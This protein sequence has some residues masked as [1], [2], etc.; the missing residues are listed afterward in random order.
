MASLMA[1]VLQ[2][3]NML[4]PSNM[5]K[6]V[7]TLYFR[8]ELSK[9]VNWVKKAVHNHNIF[10]SR[11][12]FWQSSKISLFSLLDSTLEFVHSQHAWKYLHMSL[13]SMFDSKFKHVPVPSQYEWWFHELCSTSARSIVSLIWR[14]PYFVFLLFIKPTR[15]PPSLFSSFIFW[16]WPSGLSLSEIVRLFGGSDPGQICLWQTGAR[17]LC[18]GILPQISMLLRSK[19]KILGFTSFVQN[20]KG[21]QLLVQL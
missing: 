7:I 3:K 21:M 8:P 18:C 4:N 1:K 9:V 11:L 20:C 5:V 12:L 19:G 14:W 10:Q 13:L 16:Q 17:G 15:K 6:H 2:L